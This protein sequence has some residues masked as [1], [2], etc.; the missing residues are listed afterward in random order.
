M[1]YLLILLLV[2]NSTS[3]LALGESNEDEEVQ[4]Y[5][6]KS[7]SYVQ[8]YHRSK[9]NDTQEDNYS[10]VGNVNPYTHEEGHVQPETPTVSYPKAYHEPNAFESHRQRDQQVK[11][12]F[13]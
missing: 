12:Y 2:L 10:A 7:G 13:R 4:G 9:A 6:K 3:A 1:K 8:P 11:K 5:E